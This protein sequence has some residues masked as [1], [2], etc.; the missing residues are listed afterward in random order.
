MKRTKLDLAKEYKTYYTAKPR[1]KS[2]RL[3]KDDF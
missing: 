2:L 1:P 3:E